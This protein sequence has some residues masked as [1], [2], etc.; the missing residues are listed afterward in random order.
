MRL[1]FLL[2]LA[3]PS[4]SAASPPPRQEGRPQAAVAAPDC[5]S[6][7]RLRTAQR[8]GKPAKLNRLGDEPPA[9]VVLTVYREVGGCPEPAVVYEGLGR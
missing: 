3:L 4:A 6:N 9:A 1:L 8:P 7:L 5:R 2:A